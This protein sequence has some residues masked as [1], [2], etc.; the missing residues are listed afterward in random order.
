MA[1]KPP[2]LT[3]PDYDQALKDLILRARQTFLDVFEPGM[4]WRGKRSEALPASARTADIVWEIETRSGERGILHL[5]LQVKIETAQEEKK[6]R[7]QKKAQGKAPPKKRAE[8]PKDIR[9]RMVE[10]A[11]RLYLR[12]HLPVHSVVI[13]LKRGTTPEPHFG[14][15][16]EGRERLSFNFEMIRLW[17]QSPE[18][19]LNTQEYNLWP[20]AGLMGEEVT[21]D[22]TF[23]VAEKIYQAPV[24]RQEKSRLI[25]L[26][27]LLAGIRLPGAALMQA[28]E[29]DHM[30]EE[31][32]EE[33]SYAE[34]V[35]DHAAKETTRRMAQLALQGRFGTL[36]ED[37][38][39]ALNK[40]DVAV[41]EA[42]VAHIA[43]DT[44]EQVRARLGLS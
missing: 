33:S 13:F 5:E 17:E 43:T 26:L 30:I 20:L 1:Q 12:D 15:S 37:I 36:E 7:K 14:W 19:V 23:A 29:R 16:L 8:E 34:A 35:R 42:I 3:R 2:V 27:G 38:H 9:E 21:A 31:I 10:Y 6:P 11:L 41:L 24:E 44:L 39:A 28:L 32:W 18:I 22:T 40:A 4:Q 25:G